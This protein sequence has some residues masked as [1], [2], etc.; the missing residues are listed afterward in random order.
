MSEFFTNLLVSLF[1]QRISPLMSIRYKNGPIFAL[2]VLDI[3]RTYKIALEVENETETAIAA[4]IWV[5]RD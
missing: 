2:N 1:H 3:K 5:F 4:Y